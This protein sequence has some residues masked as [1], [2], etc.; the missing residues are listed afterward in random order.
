[1]K[2][3]NKQLIAKVNREVMIECAISSAKH[4]AKSKLQL[5][6]QAIE[7]FQESKRIDDEFILDC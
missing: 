4:K 6:R 7:D 5:T 1:M 2:G 3:I